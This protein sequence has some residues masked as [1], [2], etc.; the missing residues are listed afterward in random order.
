MFTIPEGTEV[1][2]FL[3]T[4]ST[5]A[6]QESWVQAVGFLEGVELRL[7]GEATDPTRA[8][9]GRWTL[10]QLS[11]PC[12][13]V[14]G[15][16]L[17]RFTDTGIEVIA[18]QLV[19]ARSAGVTGLLLGDTTAEAPRK[20]ERREPSLPPASRASLEPTR[21]R[22]SSSAPPGEPR[23]ASVGGALRGEPREASVSGATSA[24]APRATSA[25]A[26]ETLAV[27]SERAAQAS[28]ED[29]PVSP[30]RGDLVDHFSFG[31]CEVLVDDED[32]RLKIR[33][34]KGQGRIR[35]IVLDKLE[36]RGPLPGQGGKRLFRLMRKAGVLDSSSGLSRGAWSAPAASP[37]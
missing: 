16:T 36:I 2:S 19:R 9:R 3:S 18:G 34:L 30:R 4:L 31:L 28:A 27:V 32:D 37:A 25:S 33:D 13:G 29:E 14:V 22:A 15:V 1:T 26:W 7:A 5:D 20:E 17:S 10:A 24:S 8:L 35:E 12:R 21:E 11:G 23:E 6:T